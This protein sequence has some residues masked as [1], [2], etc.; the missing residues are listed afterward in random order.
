[1][2]RTMQV[3]VA[4]AILVSTARQ[5][6][7][8]EFTSTLSSIKVRVRPGEV[9]TRS[10][11]L[12]L[13]GGQQAAARFHSHVEDWWQSED[14][15]Q[16]FYRPAGTLAHS[17][18]T[19]ITLDPVE[20]AVEPGGLLSVRITAAIP[21]H[22]APGGYWCVLTVDELPDPL[23]NQSGV[24]MRFVASVSTGIFLYVEPVQRDLRVASVDLSARQ[25][26]LLLRNVGNAPVAFQ[27]RIDVLNAGDGKV[28]ATAPLQ[29]MTVLTEPISSRLVTVALPDLAALP[30]GRYVAQVVLD[31]GL[32]H[33]I[34]VRKELVL[35]DDLLPTPKAP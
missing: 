21:R 10:F 26:R 27:G 11:E 28:A 2:K 29:R 30:P 17:C 8:I 35:P 3:W 24:D 18:G 4:L 6:S 1:M 33:D 23:A 20:T 22:V 7:A 34:G 9:V 32:D 19:W 12:H 5:A 25:A 13:A 16:S 31:I 14:G 15:A